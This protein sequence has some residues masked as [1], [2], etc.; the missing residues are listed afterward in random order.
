MALRA[1]IRMMSRHVRLESCA[2]IHIIEYARSGAGAWCRWLRD[3]PRMPERH[4][5]VVYNCSMPSMSLS[6]FSSSPSTIK[7]LM[8]LDLHHVSNHPP[9]RVC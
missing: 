1:S 7:P 3:I 4:I 2:D 6:R 8:I 9:S 5:L